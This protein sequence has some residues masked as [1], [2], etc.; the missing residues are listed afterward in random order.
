ML[1][2]CFCQWWF[3]NEIIAGDGCEE[4]VNTGSTNAAL[5][6]LA[7]ILVIIIVVV[8]YRKRLERTNGELQNHDE[9]QQHELLS[10]Q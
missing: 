10:K 9:A 6:V 4:Q 1:L 5:A 3:I 8:W 2:H 7:L